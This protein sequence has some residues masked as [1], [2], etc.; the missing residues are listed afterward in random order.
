[1]PI[2][3]ESQRIGYSKANAMKRFLRLEQTQHRD[4]SLLKKYGDF[5]QEFRDLGHLE[6]I[7]NLEL[8]VS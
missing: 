7:E 6:K 5:I 8:D 4:E 1:M 2:K 3:E